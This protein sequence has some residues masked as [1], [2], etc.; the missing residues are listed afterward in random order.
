MGIPQGFEH[1]VANMFVIPAGMLL[2]AHVSALDWWLWN[3]VPV[4]LGN[5]AGG[6][7]FTGLALHIT[8]RKLA[9][10][11][12]APVAALPGTMHGVLSGGLISARD[13]RWAGSRRDC[14]P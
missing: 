9:A 4:T 1:S 3:Q 8:H 11:A 5:V 2:G 6:V 7:I 10:S 14:G 12:P 13:D